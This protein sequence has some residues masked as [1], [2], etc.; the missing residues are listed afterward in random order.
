[1]RRRLDLGFAKLLLLS[2]WVMAPLSIGLVAVLI[3]DLVEFCRELSH[4]VFGFPDM[5]GSEVT[6]GVLKLIDLVL[7][8]NLA[9]MILGAAVGAFVR[10]SPDTGEGEMPAGMADF[11]QVKIR[12]FGY[13]SAIAAIDLLESFVNI[14][15]LK[16]EDV[17]LQIAILIVFVVSGVLLALMDRLT[18]RN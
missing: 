1:M 11:G 15:P 4:I 17:L 18:E 16:K 12:V 3:I 13:I 6:L 7:I 8:A 5:S 2:R 9:L 14:E 10:P